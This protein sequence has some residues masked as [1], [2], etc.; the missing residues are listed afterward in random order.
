MEKF[1][2]TGLEQY[3]DSQL[4]DKKLL[5]GAKEIITS[6]K[7]AKHELKQANTNREKAVLE[8]ES[9]VKELNVVLEKLK[10]NKEKADKIISDAESKAVDIL[11]VSDEASKAEKLKADSKLKTVLNRI[12]QHEAL[13]KSRLEA[14]ET[15]QIK[16]DAI[17]AELESATARF[18]KLVG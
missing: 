17:M 5:E 2:I 14:A 11:K 15:A 1:D 13:E 8:K 10:A 4:R 6:I 16:L 9:A 12:G 3:I 18:K 7:T